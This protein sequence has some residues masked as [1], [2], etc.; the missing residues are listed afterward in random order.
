MKEVYIGAFRS[1]HLPKVGHELV[2]LDISRKGGSVHYLIHRAHSIK[3]L[4]LLGRNMGRISSEN[5]KI[6]PM[7]TQKEDKG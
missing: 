7:E 2:F 1:L 4:P 5:R 6:S 3:T